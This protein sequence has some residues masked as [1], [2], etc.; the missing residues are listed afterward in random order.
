M[1]QP[2]LR[3]VFRLGTWISLRSSAALGIGDIRVSRFNWTLG[4]ANLS[5]R[6]LQGR[7]SAALQNA[8]RTIDGENVADRHKPIYQRNSKMTEQQAI[9]EAA[10]A[11]RALWKVGK[12][13]QR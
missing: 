1:G 5:P 4:G 3:L 11:L 8:L 2:D 7:Y 13:G 9:E 12:P 6:D 10:Q